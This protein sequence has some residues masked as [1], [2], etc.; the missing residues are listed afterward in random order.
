VC[1]CK[2]IYMFCSFPLN[3]DVLFSSEADP[4]GFEIP[5]SV[6]IIYQYVMFAL[7]KLADFDV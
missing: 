3:L 4:I 2:V 5:T 7:R 6:C 1:P